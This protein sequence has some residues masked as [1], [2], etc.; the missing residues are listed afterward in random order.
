MKIN[1][2]EVYDKYDGRCAYCGQKIEIKD[3]QVDHIIPKFHYSE[4]YGCLIVDGRK[5]DDYGLNDIRNLN[6]ACRSCNKFKTAF[7]LEDFRKELEAQVLRLRKY[8]NTFR[9]AERYGLVVAE[10]KPVVFY[11][12]KVN[13]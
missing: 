3:M 7:T 9:I 12:E 10:E 4:S 1:R 11:F 6:P 8:Q 5:F 2:Q 13:K